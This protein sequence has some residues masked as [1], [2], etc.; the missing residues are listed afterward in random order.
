MEKLTGRP[1]ASSE[2]RSNICNQDNVHRRFSKFVFGIWSSL[3]VEKSGH[4]ASVKLT[5]ADL[6][7]V[8][9]SRVTHQGDLGGVKL[10]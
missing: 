7:A 5:A 6:W 3:S 8:K 9:G 4:F 2:N 10:Q 1:A